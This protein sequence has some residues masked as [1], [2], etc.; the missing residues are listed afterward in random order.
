MMFRLFRNICFRLFDPRRRLGRR[1][2]DL[3]VKVVLCPGELANR[4]TK[5]TR[6]LRQF[7]RAEQKQDDEK[8]NQTIGPEQIG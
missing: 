2:C 3:A 8:K 6:E 5:A 7:L 1:P 4:L